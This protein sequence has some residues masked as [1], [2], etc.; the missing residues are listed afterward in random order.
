MDRNYATWI[1][2]LLC[3]MACAGC[4]SPSSSIQRSAGVAPAFRHAEAT[5]SKI[6]SSLASDVAKSAGSTD[7]AEGI[8]IEN[9]DTN[10]PDEVPINL[11][12]ALA[13]IDGQHPI[14]GFARWRVQESY[15]QLD[16][17]NA[18][19]L[20]TIHSGF[21][22]R[23]HD[24]NYQ[25]VDGSIADVNLNS[26]DYGL[27][28]GS[29]AAGGPPQ[30]GIAARFH[31]ADAIFLPKVA[32][33]TAWARG[34]GATATLNSQLLTAALAYTDL[35][36]ACQDQQV[37]AE[38][39]QRTDELVELTRNYAEVG[40]GLLAD[41]DRTSTELALVRTRELGVRERKLV[42]STRLARALSIPMTSSMSPQDSVLV[43]LDLSP[44]ESD[45]AT[46]IATGLAMRPELKESQALVVAA[47]EAYKREKYA[48]FVPSV[49]L[50]FSTTR[51][52]GGLGNS[53][54][55]FGGRYDVDAKMTWE[56]RNMGFAEGAAR[57]ER[58]AQVQ[59]ATF[60]KLRIMDQVAQ[61][62]AEAHVQV[63]LRQ[64]QIEVAKEAINTA[65][66]SYRRNMDRIREG[67]GLPIEALQA[68]HALETV[69]RAYVNSVASHN[70]AQFQLQWALGWPA[71]P[72]ETSA[73]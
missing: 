67:Q 18:M 40:E 55:F 65:R 71:D 38:S 3:A 47:V 63:I 32:E 48:P 46:L 61:E 43:P 30:P 9:G 36:E 2:V 53:P 22:Y 6:P 20:P 60:A 16:R 73:D 14:V 62:V 10:T 11:P 25:A 33:K 66:E 56:T 52:G 37:I 45:E 54:E 1:G 29:I 31:L 24:G 26:M 64:Q 50:G 13:L 58:N 23:R 41:A 12:T 57:R 72:E 4:A 17:A 39:V 59:Q 49:L 8:E 35:L 19:W 34:H 51:F 70:R 44:R 68:I 7:G 42:A 5:R 28:P 21:S 69:Q 27:G 15:A